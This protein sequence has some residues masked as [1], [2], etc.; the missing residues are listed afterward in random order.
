MIGQFKAWY[1][2]P[3]NAT[4]RYALH[5]WQART[6]QPG[7]AAAIFSELD[8]TLL[9]AIRHATL[10]A[11]L[12]RYPSQQAL[13][14]ASKALHDPAPQVREA[15][16]NVISALLPAEQRLDLLGPLLRDQILAVR[17]ASADALLGNAQRLGSF[18]AAFTQAIGEYEQVQLSLQERAEANLNLAMLYQAT[19]RPERV[20]PYLRTA[21]A[22]D[23]DFLPALV[24]LAQWLDG[25]GRASE[26]DALLAAKLAQAPDTALLHFSQGL[27]LVRRS[28]A[29]AAL[30]AL[31]EA[32]RLEP[33]NARYAYVLALSLQD[34]GDAPGARRL[35][36]TTLQAHPENRE[37]R[38]ALVAQ[39]RDEGEVGQM[40]GLIEGL[41]ALNP[42]DPVLH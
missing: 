34:R 42:G 7:A 6:A 20:E 5:L 26:A 18:Q 36:E 13:S 21:I 41:K 3:D 12:P 2:E 33:G 39:L 23:P 15:A 19:G 22:R 16:V 4:S 24:T 1:G 32:N 31:S 9:A 29:D 11:E 25:R 17:I 30:K 10:L 37:V 35:L 14:A 8:N 40:K 27:A 38:L 28:Q